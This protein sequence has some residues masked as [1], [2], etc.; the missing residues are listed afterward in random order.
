MAFFLWFYADYYVL[1]IAP[2]YSYVLVG[3]SS[4]KYL[5]IMSRTPAL[6]RPVL[7]SLLAKLRRRGYDTSKLIFVEQ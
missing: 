3:S 5:W 6:P 7:D 4:D 2:D 1:D